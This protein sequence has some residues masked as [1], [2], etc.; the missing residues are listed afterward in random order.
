MNKVMIFANSKQG[1]SVLDVRNWYQ[2]AQLDGDT[3]LVER[4]C[5]WYTCLLETVEPAGLVALP[6]DMAAFLRIPTELV[7]FAFEGDLLVATAQASLVRPASRCEVIVS[8]VVVESS[9]RGRGYGTTLVRRLEIL[10]ADR[11]LLPRFFRLRAELPSPQAAQFFT[12]L[13]YTIRGDVLAY[14]VR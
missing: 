1:L 8:N 14:K 7:L 10:A 5:S 4:V 6:I 2:L 9:R 13:G 12:R 11:W 3:K